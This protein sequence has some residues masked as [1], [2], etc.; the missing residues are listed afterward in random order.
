MTY[1]LCIRRRT[2]RPLGPD[3]CV[4]AKVFTARPPLVKLLNESDSE[5]ESAVTIL[6]LRAAP[7]NCSV[8][9]P[10]GRS[11]LPAL[12]RLVPRQTHGVRPLASRSRRRT[13]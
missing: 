10:A 3:G 5:S 4:S 12:K 7:S 1:H 8:K 2:C 6:M 11:P 13:R 9:W